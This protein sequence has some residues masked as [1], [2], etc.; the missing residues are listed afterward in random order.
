M[1]AGT[2]LVMLAQQ[3][4][5]SPRQA[6]EAHKSEIMSHNASCGSVVNH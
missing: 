1:T 6:L 4:T 5:P 3:S 2:A